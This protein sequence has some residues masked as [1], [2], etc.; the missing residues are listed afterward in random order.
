MAY[1]DYK[2][3]IPVQIRFC[4]ID[5]LDHVNNSVYH[6]Y[7]ELGRVTYFKEILKDRVNWS[8][9]GFILGRTEIDHRVQVHLNDDIY[10]CTKAVKFGTKSITFKNAIVKKVNGEFIECAGVIGILVAM[11]YR[12]NISIPL[13]ALWRELMEAYEK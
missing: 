10:C 2:H 1:Q 11:D 9:A 6:N 13:P 12:N 8:E 5:K 4:D 3:I 7:I